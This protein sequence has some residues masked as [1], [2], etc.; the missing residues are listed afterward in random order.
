M[1]L[2]LI[3]VDSAISLNVEVA[4][5]APIICIGYISYKQMRTLSLFFLCTCFR[6]LSSS[7]TFTIEQNN[8]DGRSD[9][10]MMRIP[11]MDYYTDDRVVGGLNIIYV[12]VNNRE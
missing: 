6:Y 9:F 3:Y 8:S 12:A 11:G 4:E 1:V 10:E 5:Y 7:Y 2:K